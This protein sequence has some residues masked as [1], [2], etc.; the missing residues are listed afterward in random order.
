MNTLLIS[1]L[2]ALYCAIDFYYTQE[3]THDSK[4]K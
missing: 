3:K 4:E 1:L 2:V